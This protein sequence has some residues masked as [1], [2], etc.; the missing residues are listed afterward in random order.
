[1]SKVASITIHRDNVGGII[2]DLLEKKIISMVF[3]KGFAI[4]GRNTTNKSTL[5]EIAVKEFK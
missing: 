5:R 3:Y 2:Q 4:I 1:M